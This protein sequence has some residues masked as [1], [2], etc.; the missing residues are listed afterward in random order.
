MAAGAA[1]FNV[2]DADGTTLVTTVV[3]A[4]EGVATGAVSRL[5]LTKESKSSMRAASRLW[6]HFPQ[7]WWTLKAESFRAESS[8]EETP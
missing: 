2:A 1:G 8:T 7:A 3:G 5:V 6:I 4:A